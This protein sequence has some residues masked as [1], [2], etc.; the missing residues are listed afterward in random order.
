MPEII[1]LYF[2]VPKPKFLFEMLS[3]KKNKTKLK[4]QTNNKV[5]FEKGMQTTMV[6]WGFLLSQTISSEK[7]S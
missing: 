2:S 4:K 1:P 5:S 7:N 6:T 3:W